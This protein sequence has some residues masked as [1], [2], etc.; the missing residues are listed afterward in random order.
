MPMQPKICLLTVLMLLLG[1]CATLRAQDDPLLIVGSDT[2]SVGELK[3]AYQKNLRCVAAGTHQTLDE[4]IAS[5]AQFRMK[6]LDAY[7]QGLAQKSSFQQEY[8]RYRD[9]QLGLYLLDSSH[10]DSTYRALYNHLAEERE[11]S[12]ILLLAQDSVQTEKAK[13]LADSLYGR[14]LAGDDF[15]TLAKA[16]SQD[17]TTA[18]QGGR[19]G[20][21]SALTMIYPFEQAVYSTPVGSVSKPFTSSLGY[22]LVKVMRTRPARGTMQAAQL[23]T[24]LPPQAAELDVSKAKH[25]M[26]SA[27]LAL[28]A[29]LSIDTLIHH[30]ELQGDSSLHHNLLQNLCAGRYPEQLVDLLFS[31]QRDGDYSPVT[32]T[33]YGWAIF[34]RIAH[35]PQPSYQKAL[36]DLRA[37]L[38]QSGQP[39][40]GGAALLAKIRRMAHLV[41]HSKNI[42]ALFAWMSQSDHQGQKPEGSLAE[43]KLFEVNRH[44]YTGSD[45]FQWYSANQPAG[46]PLDFNT[47]QQALTAYSDDL[48][49]AYAVENLTL[50]HPDL[51]Y[52][53]NEFHDGLLLF[54]I[55][56]QKIWNNQLLQQDSLKA[57]YRLH[58]GTLRYDSCY[59]VESYTSSDSLALV[60]AAKRLC[61]QKLKSLSKRDLKKGTIK[62]TSQRMSA[63]QLPP[64]LPAKQ[65]DLKRKNA[66]P[67]PCCPVIRQG[68]HFLLQRLV[69][70]ETNVPMTYQESLPRLMAL[71]QQHLL[72]R[73][74]HELAQRYPVHVNPDALQALKRSLHE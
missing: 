6:V 27:L 41:N 9:Y 64:S 71:Y 46:K 4:F 29:G 49:L 42:K 5:Y 38:E 35:S 36:P 8:A 21:I 26:D 62:V 54:D 43:A 69:A 61:T 7:A 63:Q 51:P 40:E 72:D 59:T 12:H 18:P 19:I 66:C 60:K 24:L 47:L 14:L 37:Y 55:S 73:W 50:Q 23:Y 58:Q 3:Y 34:Q 16:Y 44:G 67:N 25:N 28:R 56:D 53:L 11:V 74:Q 10:I 1:L 57:F 32:R 52:L 65:C 33:A 13:R 20:Y 30:H 39:V 15:T 68:N 31:L 2:T 45:F 70:F 48:C 22:H 17:N